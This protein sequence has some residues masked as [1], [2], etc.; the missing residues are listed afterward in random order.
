MTWAALA[1]EIVASRISGEPMPVEASLL[2]A[3]E[4]SRF[5]GKTS[6]RR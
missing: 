6:K 4:P 1:A 2:K 3:L 5:A